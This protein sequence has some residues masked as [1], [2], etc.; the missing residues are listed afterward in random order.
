MSIQILEPEQS[1]LGYVL[2]EQ[3]GSGGYGEVWRAEAPGG[4]GKAIKFIFGNHSDSRA[5]V[6]LKSLD[7]IKQVR[8]PFLLSLDRIEV[9]DG[10]LVIVSEL[11]D[12]SLVQ[13]FDRYQL[14]GLAG[15]P[16]EELLTY[17]K[18]AGDALDYISQKYNLQHL[19]IKPDNLLMAGGHIKIAD[20]GLVKNIHNVTQ[21]LMNGLTPTYA[22]PELFDGRPNKNSDQYSLAIV[23]QEML[24]GLRPFNGTTPAQLAAQH[25]NA[26]PD[27]SML[28]RGDKIVLQKALMKDPDKRFSSC[29]EMAD[30]LINRKARKSKGR[31]GLLKAA[32]KREQANTNKISSC[33]MGVTNELTSDRLAIR[34]VKVEAQ[35][36]VEMSTPVCRPTLVVGVGR[37]GTKIICQLR[38][39][40]SERIGRRDCYPAIKMICIDSDRRALARAAGAIRKEEAMLPQELLEIPL[41]APQDYRENASRFSSWLSR[42][43]IYNVPRTMQTEGLRP[44]GRL[45]FAD[46]CEEVC[47]RLQQILTDI[48]RPEAISE[49]AHHLEMDP[50]Q[51][52][53]IVLVGAASGGITSGCILDLAFVARTILSDLGVR[54]CMFDGILAHIVS[55]QTREIS[56][57]NTFACLSELGHYIHNGYPGDESLGIPDFDDCLPFDNTYLYDFGSVVT[58]ESYEEHAASI[59]EYLFQNIATANESFFAATRAIETESEEVG[60][61]SFGLTT[62]G[63]S[64]CD[65]LIQQMFQAL[66]SSWTESKADNQFVK[67]QVE[68]LTN[69]L[70]DID[71]LSKTWA[72]LTMVNLNRDGVDFVDRCLHQSQETGRLDVL[73]A[74]TS[75]L[76]EFVDNFDIHSLVARDVSESAKLF[77]ENMLRYACLCGIRLGGTISIV[78]GIQAKVQALFEEV[79]NRKQEIAIQQAAIT[80]H[81]QALAS[82]ANSGDVEFIETI[83]RFVENR[84]QKCAI[85]AINTFC[86]HWASQLSTID[87]KLQDHKRSVLLL[88][89]VLQRKAD[90]QDTPEPSNDFEKIQ[91]QIEEQVQALIPSLV[92]EAD[93]YLEETIFSQAGGFLAVIDPDGNKS[94]DLSDEMEDQSRIHIVNALQSID[95]NSLLEP[96]LEPSNQLLDNIVARSNSS[97]NK[98]GGTS[99]LLISF[100]KRSDQQPNLESLKQ[101]FRADANVTHA[102][103]GEFLICTECKNIPIS[104]FAFQ[105][106]E[107][108]PDCFDL[109]QRIHTRSDIEWINLNQILS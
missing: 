101:A 42:R 46:H 28:S 20:F 109:V 94:R 12:D 8:H 96:L 31:P 15:V 93:Q 100:P 57:S 33:H 22:P 106:L 61:K 79:E 81:L 108:H 23:Y 75:D 74:V 32:E 10:R 77:E 55:R 91:L 76:A 54:E 83:R 24:T 66:I 18:N 37:T 35:P 103:T 2:K 50:D 72:E 78:Q 71:D 3:I 60:F 40:L 105:L 25:M 38:S 4:I 89:R 65:H 13:T 69:Q 16:R 48:T 98:C 63:A 44:L 73:N 99:N 104:S 11:A 51:A 39:K 36:A 97:I 14:E 27:L 47:L 6:E 19:D 34:N 88:G 84:A 102:T 29:V 30:E 80:Q 59:S 52:P 1:I 87:E 5:Q 62:I 64:N 58:D 9:V 43:W 21:S 41:K 107:A 68:L 92:E 53:R 49:T 90:V 56:V 82:T 95:F 17:I 7:K 26:Q 45:A 86:R 85:E 70:F 67:H